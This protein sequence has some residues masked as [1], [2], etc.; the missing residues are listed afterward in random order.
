MASALRRR[1]REAYL[2][3]QRGLLPTT[4]RTYDYGLDLIERFVGSPIEEV[5]TRDVVRY[6]QESPDSPDQKHIAI[7]AA[8][9]FDRF[10]SLEL[11][12]PMSEMQALSAPRIRRDP[13]DTITRDEAGILLAEARSPVEVR[14]IYLPLFAGLRRAE[15][16]GVTDWTDRLLIG[17]AAKGRKPREIPV[18]PQLDRVKDC[19]LSE[20]PT[21]SAIAYHHARL[22]DRF[23]ITCSL[24]RLRARFARTLEEADVPEKVQ[25]QLMGHDPRVGTLYTGQNWNRKVDAIKR[26][27]YPVVRLGAGYQLRLFT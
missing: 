23:G 15:C 12:R 10:E 2:V 5:S 11:E 25:D 16:I 20:S 3:R 4:V 22:V 8:K 19:I 9:S 26:I 27:D 21:Y 14:G 18:H 17:H 6:L 24:H 13:K 1:Y 7:A